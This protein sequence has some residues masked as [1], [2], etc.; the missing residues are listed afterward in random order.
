MGLWISIIMMLIMLGAVG[1][2]TWFTAKSGASSVFGIAVPP[3]EMDSAE[4]QA[5]IRAFRRELLVWCLVLVILGVPIALMGKWSALQFPIMLIW[6]LLAMWGCWRSYEKAARK[7]LALRK[8]NGWPIPSPNKLTVDTSVSQGRAKMAVSIWWMLPGTIVSVLPLFWFLTHPSSG[9]LL[10]A[11]ICAFLI[12]GS[13]W[14]FRRACMKERALAFSENPDANRACHYAAIRGWT[15]SIAIISLLT[16][17][18]LAALFAV[19]AGI[20]PYGG[21]I[22]IVLLAL[23]VAI[24]GGMLLT[25]SR[26]RA[27]QQKI[28]QKEPD[29][30]PQEEN[31]SY[32]KKGFYNNPLDPRICVPKRMG[33][34]WTF[35]VGNPVGKLLMA[36]TL[37][38]VGLMVAGIFGVII[39]AEVAPFQLEVKGDMVSISAPLY[40]EDFPISKLEEVSIT[41]TI[42][43]GARTN[44]MGT[45]S[46]L[47]GHFRLDGVG[48]AMLYVRTKEMPC[49]VL[50]FGDC[51]VY[52]TADSPEHTQA[53][54]DQLLELVD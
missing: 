26:I 37:G 42:P 2:A 20:I 1:S 54:Y 33:I 36:A 25:M 34:G 19:S 53:L 35:N 12:E 49:L 23:L 41:D 32:W 51:T 38:L 6:F 24:L 31:V 5:H 14:L 10:A 21:W 7:M 43:S 17:L 29:V 52:F 39:W 40:G 15:R 8:E 11:A 48:N 4:I 27:K 16:E 46:L 9:D 13:F 47:L 45:G 50:D 44:G 30:I 3:A 28:L 18:V 22:D